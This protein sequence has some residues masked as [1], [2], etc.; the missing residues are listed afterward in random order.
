MG[1]LTACFWKSVETENLCNVKRSALFSKY[2][3]S[4]HQKFNNKN[5]SNEACHNAKEFGIKIIVTKYGLQVF[6]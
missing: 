2:E 4:S 6:M 1:I 5:R 3:A